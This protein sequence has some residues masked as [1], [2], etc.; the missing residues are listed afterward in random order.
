MVCTIWS[1]YIAGHM[2]MN[3]HLET[4]LLELV[5]SSLPLEVRNVLAAVVACFCTGHGV[6]AE[7]FTSLGWYGR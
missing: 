7:G 3:N 5:S 1:R 6:T 2:G 4:P